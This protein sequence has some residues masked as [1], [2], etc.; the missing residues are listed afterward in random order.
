MKMAGGVCEK[1]AGSH[2]NHKIIVKKLSAKKLVV[3]HHC[4]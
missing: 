1:K 2:M 4:D 3:E